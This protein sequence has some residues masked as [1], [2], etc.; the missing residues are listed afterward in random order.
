MNDEPRVKPEDL[1]TALHGYC[2]HDD[3]GQTNAR[4]IRERRKKTYGRET[5]YIDRGGMYDPSYKEY[6]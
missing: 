6:P 5:G 3:E 4:D 2:C 1:P